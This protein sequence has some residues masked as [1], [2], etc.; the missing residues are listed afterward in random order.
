ML[1]N[2]VMQNNIQ[3]W[4]RK[5]KVLAQAFVF[6][7]TFWLSY[8]FEDIENTCIIFALLKV[9]PTVYPSSTPW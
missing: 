8:G 3:G 4:E 2:F 7:R 5:A 6:D 1:K 9:A